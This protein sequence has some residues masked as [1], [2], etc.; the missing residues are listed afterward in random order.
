MIF[1]VHDPS[2]TE[3]FAPATPDRVTALTILPRLCRFRRLSGQRLLQIRDD[4]IDMLKSHREP[5][6]PVRDPG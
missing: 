4:I 6:I 1:Q 5:H 2:I 3:S